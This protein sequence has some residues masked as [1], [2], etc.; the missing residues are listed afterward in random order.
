MSF[1]DSLETTP[2]QQVP[3]V[4]HAINIQRVILSVSQGLMQVLSLALLLYFVS[5]TGPYASTVFGFT[6][7]FCQCH[8]A[9]CK[10]C[11]WL[12]F[13]ILSVSQGLMQVL[14]LALLLYFVSVTGPY[15][16]TVFGFTS[17]FY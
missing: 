4:R 13:C 7:V 16:S 5:V 14:S 8:R 6:S 3:K 1:G 15:A 12:Y 11:L 2:K 9:L 10:Y 17:V